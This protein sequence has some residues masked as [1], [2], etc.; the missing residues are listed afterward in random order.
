MNFVVSRALAICLVISALPVGAQERT[1]TAVSF[2]MPERTTEGL[3]AKASTPDAIRLA[4]HASKVGTPLPSSFA[5]TDR[6]VMKGALIGFGIGALLGT[7]V[8]QE[9]CLHSPRWHCAVGAGTM[10]GAIGA[11]IV[12]LR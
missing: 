1:E 10:L 5:K 7:T 3:F 11:V 12:W 6:R 9:A 8:G 4:V 2:D